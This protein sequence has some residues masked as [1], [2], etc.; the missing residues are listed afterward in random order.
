MLNKRLNKIL[1]LTF[2]LMYFSGEVALA[3]E[4]M[5]VAQAK[6]VVR[7]ALSLGMLI[8][9]LSVLWQEFKSRTYKKIVFYS[10]DEAAQR[11]GKFLGYAELKGRKLNIRV[12]DLVLERMLKSS[13]VATSGKTEVVVL[14]DGRKILRGS[15]IT[16]E[17]G[18]MEHFKAI[19]KIL[20][21][22]GYIGELVN[23]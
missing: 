22:S 16:Y 9:F 12:N 13:F 5:A 21:E 18:T 1:S 17:S 20:R 11:K 14:P 19:I 10:F 4:D 6:T 8:C 3:A 2:V 7:I 23:G 15:I